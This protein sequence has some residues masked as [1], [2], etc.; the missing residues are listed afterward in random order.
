LHDY[1]LYEFTIVVHKFDERRRA[2]E[3]SQQ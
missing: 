3:E 2:G 1:P